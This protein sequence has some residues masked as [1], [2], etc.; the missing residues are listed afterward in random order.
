[1]P[2][3]TFD[4]W[5]QATLTDVI[6]RPPAGRAPGAAED[7]PNLLG[8]TIAPLRSYP[9]RTAKVRVAELR[10]FGTGQFRAPD[11]TPALFKPAVQWSEQ[12]L[13][14]VL[15]DEMERI[16]EED[17]LKLNSADEAVKRS[18]GASL[19]DRGRILQLR[20][21]RATE[22]MRWQAFQGQVTVTYPTGSQYLVDYGLPTG[23]KPTVSTL[24]SDTTNADPVADIQAWSELIAADSG[25]YG[26]TLHM[27]SKT[28]NYLIQNAKVKSAIN[29]YAP[30]A[31][32]IYRP[33]R[34]DL[35]NLF[36]SFATDVQIKIYDNGYRDIGATT[37]GVGSITKYLPDGK[38]LMTT[39]YTLD[40]VNIADTLDGQ[41][42]VSN[43]YNSVDIRQGEQAEVLLDHISHT[44]FMR[45]ASA[46]I[47]RLLVPEAFIYATVA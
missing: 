37:Y 14:L 47:P 9:G 15:I 38:V 43:G 16:S 4:L 27:N 19:V 7:S 44:H 12:I 13:E 6:Q 18:A 5:D 28:Y 24:W 26:N 35:L 10:P 21:V 11:A 23:H 46:R 32:T 20:N 42:V 25:F 45:Y 17:W 8:E 31:N 41:I 30:S 1:M 3:E 39:D 29:F 40:G 34:E 2:F 33:R 22:K 36:T